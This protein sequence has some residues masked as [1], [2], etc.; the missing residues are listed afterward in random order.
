MP[1][2]RDAVTIADLRAM[3]KR[4]L[5]DFAFAPMEAGCGDG[6]GPPGNV[7]A[8]ERYR[9]LPRALVDTRSVDQRTSLFGSTYDCPFGI[10]AVGLAD[11]MR[12]GT[13]IALATAAAE[14][15]IPFILS[16]GSTT[17]VEE[18]APIAKGYL[19]QQLYAARDQAITDDLMARAE[20]TGC[21]V[22]VFTVDM[23]AP[24]WIEWLQRA[25]IA[26]PSS[27]R[28]RAWPHVLAELLRH[29]RWAI[30]HA[31]GGGLPTFEGW[32]PYAVPGASRA[33]IAAFAG[34]Q[35]LAGHDWRQLEHV[36][37][38]WPGTL[39]VKGLLHPD[40]VRRATGMGAD[41]V[42]VSNHG[43]N[44][45]DRV[46][47][48]L[49]ALPEAVAANAGTVPVLFDGG[50]RR[51]SDVMVARGLGADFSFVGRAALYGALAGGTAGALRAIEILRSEVG[52]TLAQIGCPTFSDFDGSFLRDRAAGSS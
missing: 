5:P 8:F 2:V 7:A 19:W 35:M 45:N 46:L 33:A 47:A 39:V 36:R 15:R 23:L 27:V 43:G 31:R 22:L 18:I 12:P 48:P 52:R 1:N 32:R 41:A 4:R 28:R 49:E 38:R 42:T 29:P 37:R 16:G 30:A 20:R 44:R 25:G 50:I 13:D 11:R 3:A 34:A 10:S 51:G 40:D 26:L 6:G 9:I 14:M 21:S 24:L 17:P